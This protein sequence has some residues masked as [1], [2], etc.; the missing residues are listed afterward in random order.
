[1]NLMVQRCGQGKPSEWSITWLKWSIYL[2]NKKRLLNATWVGAF[3]SLFWMGFFEKGRPAQ[4]FY[5][6]LPKIKV[7]VYFCNEIIIHT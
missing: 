7:N 1:M 3:N 6:K 5:K 2:G 4:Y